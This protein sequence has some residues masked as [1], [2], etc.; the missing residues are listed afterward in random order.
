MWPRLQ[1]VAVAVR[2]AHA[3]CRLGLLL[4]SLVFLLSRICR[5]F[6]HFSRTDAAALSTA[7]WSGP[8]S[9]APGHRSSSRESLTQAYTAR[10]S[11][12]PAASTPSVQHSRTYCNSIAE[13]IVTSHMDSTCTY[14]TSSQQHVAHDE[15]VQQVHDI[16]VPRRHRARRCA[17]P[18]RRDLALRGHL[19]I[20][21]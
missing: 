18:L 13:L 11:T 7:R 8:A 15:S 21:E 12:M 16:L 6:P 5:R 2:L 20:A 14:I 10:G 1:R 19:D 4:C 9:P 17:Q 3:V